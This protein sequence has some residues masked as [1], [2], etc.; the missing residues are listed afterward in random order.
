MFVQLS[1]LHGFAILD[2]A[3]RK[4][5]GRVVLPEIPLEKRDPGPFNGSPSHGIGV[6]PD[7][8]TLWVC[9]RPN[10]EV[11]V[12]SLPDLKLLG[13]VPVGGRP[14]WVTFTPD[15]KRIYIATENTDSVTV[16]DVATIK[17]VARVPVGASPKRNITAVLR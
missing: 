6:A 4:E 15:S 10:A 5:V 3:A 2:F 7:G 9:S 13:S 17:E 1:E 16:I 8:R 12:Y 11:Y 14:D